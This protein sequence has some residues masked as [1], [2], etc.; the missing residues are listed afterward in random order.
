MR[1]HKKKVRKI[2]TYGVAG[3][4]LFLTGCGQP[5]AVTVTV[6]D[7]AEM[8]F[9]PERFVIPT[10][11]QLLEEYLETMT[12]EEKVG[13]LFYVTMGN[14]SQPSLETSNSG[15]TVTDAEIATIQK[16]QPGGV[17]LMGGNIQSDAQVQELTAA[18]QQNSRTPMFIGVDEE[19]GIVSR[20]GSAE[21]ISMGNVGTMQSIGATGDEAKAYET[22]ATLAND[23]SALGFNMDFAPVADVLTNPNNYE[24]GSRS[25]GSDSNQVSTMVAS[26]IC[27]LQENGV[28]AVTKH[29]PGHGGVIGNSHENLQYVDT[30]LDVLRQQEFQPFQSAIEVKTDAILVSHLVLRSVDAENPSTLSESVVTGLLREELGYDGVIMT[31]S[32]QMGSITENYGQSEAAVTSIQAGCDMILMPM[33]YEACYQGVLQ[34]VQDGRISEEQINASCMRILRAKAERGILILE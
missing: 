23:L 19:G 31:D 7:T 9:L 12:L 8:Q 24:I 2:I 34:A 13:Q 10:Q 18:L 21:G 20:L 6:T 22:G 1:I 30:T 29:F 15:L 26:E 16:F 17:I 11:E 25:F 28:S 4:L 5:E 33:E 14:L 3:M 32:F 27:G